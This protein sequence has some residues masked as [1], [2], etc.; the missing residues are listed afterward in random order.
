MVVVTINILV[1]P[2]LSEEILPEVRNAVLLL[3]EELVLLEEEERLSKRRTDRIA[4][5]SAI[6]SFSRGISLPLILAPLI[7]RDWSLLLLN[8]LGKWRVQSED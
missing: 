4:E 6:N 3:L 8:S 2:L 1:I 7:S 5:C